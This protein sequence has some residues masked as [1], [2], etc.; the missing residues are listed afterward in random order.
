MRKQLTLCCGAP[1]ILLALAL[2]CTG[3]GGTSSVSKKSVV[4]T[5]TNLS[6]P[7]EHRI[8]NSDGTFTTTDN[9]I[10][11]DLSDASG[12][13]KIDGNVVTLTFT[14]P[15]GHTIHTT[16]KG[17]GMYGPNGQEWGKVP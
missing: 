10:Y 8:L 15:S 6:S 17:N 9:T 4:G 7:I 14:N 16:I 1:L 11:K 3:C 2:V 12:T 13:Y 5:W